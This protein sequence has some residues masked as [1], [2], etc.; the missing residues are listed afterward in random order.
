MRY[1]ILIMISMFLVSCSTNTDKTKDIKTNSKK[2]ILKPNI[3]KKIVKKGDNM[4]KISPEKL[5]LIKGD[6]LGNL[7]VND[8]QSLR[9]TLSVSQKDNKLVAEMGS[10]D[11]MKMGI[12]IDSITYIDDVL[13]FKLDKLKISFKGKL[14]NNI[15][16]GTFIQNGAKFPLELSKIKSLNSLKKVYKQMPKKPYPYIEEEITFLNKKDNIELAGTLTYPQSDK[17]KA[18]P[19]VIL[20]AGSGPNDRNETPIKHF[21]YIA[22]KLTKQG[23]AVL[24]FDKRG[25]K[26]SKGDYKSAT[27]YDFASDVSAAIDY[28]LTKKIINKE[29]IGLFGHSEGAMIAPLV[30]TQRKDISFLILMGT[31][32]VDGENILLQ[33]SE[34][35]SRANG[36][37]EKKVKENTEKNRK[38]YDLVK[39]S[40]TYKKIDA[41]KKE[42]V[43]ISPE[44]KENLKNILSP[45]FVKFLNFKPSKYLEKIT[46]PTLVL[47]GELDLQVNPIPNNKAIKEALDKAKNKNYKIITF[48]K[49]NHLFQTAKTGNPNEYGKLDEIM[50]EKVMETVEKWL[51]TLK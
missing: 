47:S 25:I 39:K 26:K 41:L 9:I 49:L 13:E 46:I 18:F 35:I 15:L 16:K 5:K 43:K 29:K 11:Q 24:R 2:E 3:N 50:N 12:H 30:A 4:Q 6:W 23:Y 40:K 28:L 51:K 17:F 31:P 33:Q 8:K 10:P 32:G 21:L 38:I 48:K 7:K 42:L 45:W 27:T 36:V 37:D 20:I 19:A 1:L 44:L 22:D 14:D 34:D